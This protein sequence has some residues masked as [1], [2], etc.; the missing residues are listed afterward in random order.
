MSPRLLL[1]DNYDSFTFNLYQA[2]A[3]VMGTPPIVVTND[4]HYASVRA[5]DFDGVVLSPGPGRPMVARDFGICA[6]LIEDVDVPILGICLG[7]WHADLGCM[8]EK[9]NAHT[10]MHRHVQGH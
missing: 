1:V 5:L 6:R 8:N 10:Q 7:R 4:A 3:E 9:T 2:L